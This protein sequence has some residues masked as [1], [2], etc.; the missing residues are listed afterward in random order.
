MLE[1][2][3]LGS[4]EIRRGDQVQPLRGRKAWGL[5]AYLILSTVERPS[6]QHLAELLFS[7]AADP[8]RALRWNLTELRGALGEDVLPKGEAHL[9][10]ARDIRVDVEELTRGTSRAALRL[11][12]IGRELLEGMDFSASSSFD[13]WLTYERRRLLGAACTAMHEAAL[14]LLA[15][16]RPAGA[17]PLARR[18]VALEPF[19]ENFREL[20]IRACAQSGDHKAAQSQL[21]ASRRFF[22]E[23]LGR[24]PA[25]SLARAAEELAAGPDRGAGAAD[26]QHVA[27]ALIKAGETAAGAGAVDSALQS[28]RRAVGMARETSRPDLEAGALFSLGSTL[29]H[30]VKGRDEEAASILR[31]AATQAEA[32]GLPDLQA[33]ALRELSYVDALAGRYARCERLLAEAASIAESGE[34]EAAIESVRALS[35][36]D[37]GQHKEAIVHA[38]RAVE[39]AGSAGDLK[40]QAY[41]LT[42]VGRSHFLKADLSAARSSLESAL[43]IVDETHWLAFASW[44]LAWLAEVEL[45]EGDVSGARRRME[46]SFALACE[47]RDPCWEGMA[48]RGL[49]LLDEEDGN[50]AGALRRL[51]DARNRAVRTTD[52]YVWGEAYALEAMASVAVRMESS[53]A[54]ALVEDLRSLT[55]KTG[56]RELACRGLLL[57]DQL[58]EPGALDA[59]RILAAEIQNPALV[60]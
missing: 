19:D 37:C 54:P 46:Y 16:E 5:L 8:L 47:F 41:T 52:C 14:D 20:L 17:I 53:R 51:E 7:D 27:L 40:R 38:E 55:G 12:G 25:E 11:T 9:D 34:E 31:R 45:A 50:P 13:S 3:L 43:A 2:Q 22:R 36:A 56:M 44:P 15:E 24:E 32:Q 26:V 33:G 4:P 60:P 1:I 39:L 42:L 18:L 35:A 28:L 6:R 30:A 21:E 10:A 49:G 29:V 23:E 59:A 48:G 58:G 57:A